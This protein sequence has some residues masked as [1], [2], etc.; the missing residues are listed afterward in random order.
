M[1][2][3]TTQ[4]KLDRI[5]EIIETTLYLLGCTTI[6]SIVVGIAYLCVFCNPNLN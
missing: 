4:A 3:R 2:M 1:N 5:S 6:L